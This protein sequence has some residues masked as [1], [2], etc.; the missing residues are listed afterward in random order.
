MEEQV[1]PIETPR[2]EQGQKYYVIAPDFAIRSFIE[3][4]DNLDNRQYSIYNYFTSEGEAI[5]CAE[6]LKEY[7][8]ELR[9][10]EYAKGE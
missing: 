7:L 3:L 9:K 2:A 4:N 8:I 5:I 10:E 6:K 1:K